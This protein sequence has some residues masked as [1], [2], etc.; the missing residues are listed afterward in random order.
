MLVYCVFPIPTL[1]GNLEELE[2]PISL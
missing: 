1:A 2:E